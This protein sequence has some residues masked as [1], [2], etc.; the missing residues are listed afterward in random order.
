MNWEDMPWS[1]LKTKSKSREK[2]NDVTAF[3]IL[4]FL[5]KPNIM[6]ISKRQ[7]AVLKAN[8]FLVNY[9]QFISDFSESPA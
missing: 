1:N 2:K 4:A 7:T 6:L 8:G 5:L 9:K 3:K